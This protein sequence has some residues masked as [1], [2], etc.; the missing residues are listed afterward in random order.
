MQNYDPRYVVAA[1]GVVLDARGWIL[2]VRGDRR[3]WEPPGGQ[4]ELGEDLVTALKRGVHEESGCEVEV[5]GPVCVHSN[6]G[7]PGR[8]VPEQLVPSSPAGGSAVSRAPAT[9]AP[10]P[11]CSPRTRRLRLV[12]A[13]QQRETSQDALGAEGDPSR[14]VRYRPDRTRPYETFPTRLGGD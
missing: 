11:T 7:R 1:T 14:K 3:G 12:E 2:L 6:P 4:V 5:G 13:P 10:T 9:S 8:G